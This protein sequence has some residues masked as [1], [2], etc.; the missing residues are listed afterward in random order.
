VSRQTLHAEFGTKE[1]LGQAL[2]LREADAFLADVRRTLQEHPGDLRAAIHHAVTRTLELLAGNP[3]LRTVLAGSAGAGG[4]T[5][6]PLLTSRGEPLL[7][8]AR[9]VLA[10]WLEAQRGPSPVPVVGLADSTVRLVVSHA[11][12]PL[13]PPDAVGARLAD[14]VAAGVAGPAR[15]CVS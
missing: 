1:A 4:E 14:M 2:V 11:L 9:A 8:R 6:L 15:P 10:D 13:E 5:L 7:V 12:T 3:L